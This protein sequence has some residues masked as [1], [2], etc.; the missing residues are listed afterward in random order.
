MP[1]YRFTPLRQQKPNLVQQIPAQAYRCGS[2]NSALAASFSTGLV[3][4]RPQSKSVRRPVR[5]GKHRRPHSL[6]LKLRP[7]LGYFCAST[8]S[9]QQHPRPRA[10]Q[11][12]G[13]GAG[14]LT[15]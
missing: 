12:A 7:T 4:K 15:R 11:K 10:E 1:P 8:P 9:L 5:L 13:G 6:C 3:I 2:P 14:R